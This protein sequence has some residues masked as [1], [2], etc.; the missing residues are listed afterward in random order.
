MLAL[1]FTGLQQIAATEV[2]K[3]VIQQATD[4][5]VKV[6]LCGICGRWAGVARQCAA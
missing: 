5:L 2:P 1:T 3:P 4:V 6:T